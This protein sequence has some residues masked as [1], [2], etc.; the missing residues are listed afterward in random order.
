[1]L[2]W[3]ARMRLQ[4]EEGQKQREVGQRLR[5]ARHDVGNA[6]DGQIVVA[7]V[8]DLM[9]QHAGELG[10]IEPAQQALGDAD[11]G[12]VGAAGG[13]RVERGAR[14]DVDVGHGGELGAPA[15]RGDHLSDGVALA[16]VELPRAIHAHHHLGRHARR[17]Q[18][19]AERSRSA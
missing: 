3:P 16:R 14:D 12:L 4:V 10:G 18:V 13:E 15:E 1:M 8:A 9:R 17:E 7:H 11:H 5:E 19:E 6:H 2:A